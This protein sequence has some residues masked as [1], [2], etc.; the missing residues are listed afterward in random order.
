MPD[1]TQPQ[2]LKAVTDDLATRILKAWKDAGKLQRTYEVEPGQDPEPTGREVSM[3]HIAAQTVMIEVMI[4]AMVKRATQLAEH[5][6]HV[7]VAFSAPGPPQ[8]FGG[9]G[10]TKPSQG[11]GT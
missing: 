7:N 2:T 3:A 6:S 8:G 1:A 9:Y 5:E 10:G 11:G 4:E